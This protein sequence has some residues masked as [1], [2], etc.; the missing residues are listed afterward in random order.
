MD[1]GNFNLQLHSIGGGVCLARMTRKC[2]ENTVT[3]N[4]GTH[5]FCFPPTTCR[6]STN[7]IFSTFLCVTKMSQIHFV[8]KASKMLGTAQ[9]KIFL[10]TNVGK[11]ETYIKHAHCLIEYHI[12][13][14]K[15]LRILTNA[16]TRSI[17]VKS[18]HWIF[19]VNK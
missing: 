4:Q 7:A 15:H 19:T 18:D 10:F 11:K 14:V 6:D 9:F 1:A 5:L 16:T 17:A 3:D 2:S 8:D 12:D 13:D